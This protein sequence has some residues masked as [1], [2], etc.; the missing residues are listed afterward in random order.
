MRSCSES[1]PNWAA[2]IAEKLAKALAYIHKSGIVHRD[3]KP[4]NILLDTDLTPQLADFGLAHD[5]G[6][7]DLGL[8]AS[9]W[10]SDDDRA[11]WF[12]RRL[13]AGTVYQ[14]RCDYLD[15]ALAW[16]GFKDSGKGVTLSRHGY[17]HLTREK[18]IHRRLATP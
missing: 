15:P 10:T 12:A 11:E 18:S 9:V 14:N 7:V 6:E 3:V 8:T 13:Q 4:S 17:A 2:R 5:K 16:T 1:T